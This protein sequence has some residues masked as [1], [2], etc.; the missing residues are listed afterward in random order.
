MIGQISFY[1]LYLPWLMVLALGALLALWA[2]RRLLAR[3]GMYRW[4]WHP[5][6]FDSALYMVLLYGLS[7]ASSTFW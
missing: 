2:L 6:L 1:G 3:L 5:A 7:Q 4:V